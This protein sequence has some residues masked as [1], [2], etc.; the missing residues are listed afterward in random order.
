MRVPRSAFALLPALL[1]LAG[2][3][4]AVNDLSAGAV[5]FGTIDD[6]A[7]AEAVE[8][9]ASEFASDAPTQPAEPGVAYSGMLFVRRESRIRTSICV[10]LS[11]FRY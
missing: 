2:T 5:E 8:A 6:T 1:L 7:T 4:H 3:A 11:G 9:S 10:M